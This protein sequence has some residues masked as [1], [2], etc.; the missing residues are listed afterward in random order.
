MGKL[1]KPAQLQ[2]GQEQSGEVGRTTLDGYRLSEGTGDIGL[3]PRLAVGGMW[4]QATYRTPAVHD[5]LL[6]FPPSEL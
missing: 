1:G 6:E 2:I 4:R 3:L 5:C